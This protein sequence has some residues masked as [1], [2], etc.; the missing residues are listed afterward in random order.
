MRG[1]GC[2]R[3]SKGLE[4]GWSGE[5]KA[6]SQ[7]FSG[8]SVGCRERRAESETR[9][10][11][12]LGGGWVA[13]GLGGLVVESRY[14]APGFAV[15]GVL[16]TGLREGSEAGARGGLEWPWNVF[17]SWLYGS[18]LG[19]SERGARNLTGDLTD[20]L[21]ARLTPCLTRSLTKSGVREVERAGKGAQETATR[22]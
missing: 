7:G 2:F 5:L 15:W 18:V 9:C 6:R 16:R 12:S 8:G 13:Y 3:R 1:D 20:C 4:L 17:S 14:G 22:P 21:T 10:A 11:A 19:G